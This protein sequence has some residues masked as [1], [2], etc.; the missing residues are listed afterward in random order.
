METSQV[1]SSIDRALDPVCSIWVGACLGSL[2]HVESS[3]RELGV[4]VRPA[5]VA[6]CILQ[7]EDLG[8]LGF[9]YHRS[10]PTAHNS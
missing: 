1:L 2:K 5:R 7:S 4:E 9:G 8:Y 3:H 10:R 6:E